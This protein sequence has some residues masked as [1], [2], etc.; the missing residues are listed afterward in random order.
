MF[1]VAGR[2]SCLLAMT[3]LLTATL[4]FLTLHAFAQSKLPPSGLAGIDWSKAV[5]ITVIMD[6]YEFVPERLTFQRGVPARLHLVNR[7]GSIHDFT[8][9]DFFKTVDLRDPGVIGASGIGVYRR[10]APREG[11]GSRSAV[12]RSRSG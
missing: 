5:R 8:A 2:K 10:A 12:A 6:D 4:A 11:C 9:A 7:S 1:K 3:L